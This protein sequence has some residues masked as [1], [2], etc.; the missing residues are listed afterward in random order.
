MKASWKWLCELSGVDATPEQMAE[1][2]TGAGLEVEGLT[3][4]G[5][6]LEHIVVV[7]VR[8][9]KPHPKRDNLS[10]VTVW[11]GSEL[12]EV[13]CGAPNV[14]ANSGRVV[15][16]KLGA[17]LPGGLEIA[18]RAVG[19]ITSKGMLCS[20]V[21]LDAGS[22]GDGIMILDASAVPGTPVVDAL[23]LRDATLEIGLTP[24]RPDCLGHVG[25]A[26]E[27]S[28][29]FGVPFALPR[30]ATLTPGPSPIAVRID[31][32][33]RCPRYGAGF[34][35]GV[36][37]GPSPF[38]ARYRLHVL[39]IRS[40]SN[41]VDATNLIM[42]GW[43][44]PIHAFDRAKLK[45][46][47]I[48]V[49]VG[50]AGEKTTTLDGIERTVGP[51]DL[52]ICDGDT[53]VAV[54][55]VMGGAN[56][57][58]DAATKDVVIECA[59]FDPR[60][61]RRT[62]RRLGMHTDASHRF[63]RGVDPEA[64]AAVLAHATTLIAGL[65]GGTAATTSVDVVAKPYT[66][67]RVELRRNK[68]ERLLGRD[69]SSDELGRV[70]LGLG[71]KLDTTSEGF[72]VTTPSWRPDLGREADLAEE[73]A[74]IVGY[75]TIPIRVPQVAPSSEGT[76]ARLRFIRA[77]REHAAATGL[78]EVVN[79]AFVAPADLANAKVETRAV[80]LMNPL[81]EERS[82][83]RTSLLPGMAADVRRARH[84]QSASAALFEVARIFEATTDVLP[85]EQLSLGVLL[86]GERP[87]WLKAEG[88]Y[89]F[90]DLK[91]GLS[92][93]LRLAGVNAAQFEPLE[94]PVAF[95]HPRRAA[96]VYVQGHKVGVMGELHP[97]VLDAF[98]LGANAAYAELN[99]DLLATLA[100]AK[101]LPKATPLAKFPASTRDISVI[102]QEEA[103]AAPIAATLRAAAGALI[104]S[105]ELFDVY[106]G[107]PIP[108]GHKSL[109]F[110]LSYRDPT[111]TLTDKAVD[112]A[113]ALVI[114]SAEQ[115]FGAKLRA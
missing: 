60:S 45:S 41:V 81:S 93:V 71:C 70:L 30:A 48:G 43:G 37:V 52:L 83:L 35:A 6:G 104:E 13:V 14:P 80:P 21:E 36:S 62:A 63:E 101:L 58:I 15:L 9:R 19:G 95:L 3:H 7:E 110:H 5:A 79:Y 64:V 53:P 47:V 22:D 98:E 102:V 112:A 61:V 86:A 87:G 33:E 94:A 100:A 17:K 54:A 77:L 4:R 76:P 8:D 11:D 25:L 106:R 105:V 69:A 90:H 84:H 74:R 111:G 44:H 92:A 26:R 16:A 66:P 28:L 72:T 73:F 56:S 113:H 29:L 38:W 34:V 32:A 46:G 2:L 23:Q 103:F 18:E 50:R 39:G 40:I 51:D 91:G 65:A 78:T 67:S 99:A 88:A 57:E 82:V 24:N 109:A 55:G 107:P 115:N 42:L 49:R 12:H 96:A 1:R 114:K 68:V 31:D 27:L 85:R 59:Y 10:L 20:E 97:D 108:E 75:D 89:D